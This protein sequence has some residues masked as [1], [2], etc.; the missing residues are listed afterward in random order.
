MAEKEH[1]HTN[2][3]EA[4]SAILI[5]MAMASMCFTICYVWRNAQKFNFMI[6]ILMLLLFSAVVRVVERF[7]YTDSLFE[8]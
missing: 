7:N 3:P 8:P 5:C 1:Q 6:T 2:L 4:M